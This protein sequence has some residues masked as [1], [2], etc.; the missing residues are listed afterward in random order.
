MS[1]YAGTKT[2]KN[3]KEAFAGESQARNRYTFFAKAASEAGLEQLAEIYLETAEQ[4]KQH[5]NIWFN[6]FHGAGDTDSN[7]TEAADG[8]NF[9]WSEMYAR[10]SREAKEEGFDD[11]AKKFAAVA[12]VEAFHEKRYL[13]IKEAIR[14]NEIHK[15]D[16]PVEWQCKKCGY[17]VKGT[18]APDECPVCA[19]PKAYF[20][21]KKEIHY[22]ISGAGR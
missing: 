10:M 21:K 6:E 17:T 9:E 4:E 19:A 18:T 14:N 11:L 1:K 2:E 22:H 5:A 13:D 20:E 16:K 8:E 15:S 12:S 3:L 7:L